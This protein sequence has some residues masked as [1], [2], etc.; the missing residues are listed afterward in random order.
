MKLLITGAS[1][2]IGRG[3]AEV[4]AEAGHAVGLLARSTDLLQQIKGAM[5]AAGQTCAIATADLR[6][7]DDTAPAIE[8]LIKDLGG[9]D[10]LINNA[11]QIVRQSVL[12]IP[13]DQWQSMIETNINGPFYTTRSVL[14]VMKRQGHGHIVNISSISGYMPLPDG[15]GYAASKYALTGFSESLFQAVR[16]WGVKVT[17]VFPGS[18]DSESRPVE[19]DS[20]WKVTPREVGQALLNLLETRPQNLIS[21][22]EIRPLTS[23][24]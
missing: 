7:F 10:A 13:I 22:L 6:S 17:T 14:P 8:S 9:V 18:V 4:L 21:K 5:D 20:S 23:G 11:G 1:K 19:G 2:G 24:G 3:I 12:D 15:P 16:Q